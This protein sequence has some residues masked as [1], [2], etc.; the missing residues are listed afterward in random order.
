MDGTLSSFIID[1]DVL[2]MS[3]CC[4]A[5][6]A[7][8]PGCMCAS[9]RRRA[10]VGLRHSAQ[11]CS[12]YLRAGCCQFSL[13]EAASAVSIMYER[14]LR[15]RAVS[16]FPYQI[17]RKQRRNLIVCRRRMGQLNLIVFHFSRRDGRRREAEGKRGAGGPLC[18]NPQEK[19]KA[20]QVFRR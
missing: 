11:V 6:A 10:W 19:N 5:A 12:C 8:P 4:T 18:R 7:A 15:A 3:R 17:E 14:A 20:S 1:E 9:L 16:D 13:T 2:W